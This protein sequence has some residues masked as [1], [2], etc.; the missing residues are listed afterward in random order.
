MSVLDY[1][2]TLSKKDETASIRDSEV[3]HSVQAF[4][5]IDTE[6]VNNLDSGRNL[7]NN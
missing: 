5:I 7:L 3:T 2:T 1:I 6:S 4:R